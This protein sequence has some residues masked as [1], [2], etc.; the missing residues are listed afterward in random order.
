MCVTHVCRAWR[1]TALA[2]AT[3]WCYIRL[4]SLTTL[5]RVSIW[6]E[7]SQQ[8][9][10]DVFFDYHFKYHRSD[11]T[12]EL[13]GAI[14]R[15]MY[16]IRELEMYVADEDVFKDIGTLDYPLERLSV[17]PTS[18][19]EGQ[20]QLTLL[21]DIDT[22]FPHLTVL[23]LKYFDLD[24]DSIR[25]PTGLTDLTLWEDSSLST[26]ESSVEEMLKLLANLPL[27]EA[28]RCGEWY[29]SEDTPST[30]LPVVHLPRLR[31]LFLAQNLRPTIDLIA[32]LSVPEGLHFD[33]SIRV[34]RESIPHAANPTIIAPFAEWVKRVKQPWCTASF[35]LELEGFPDEDVPDDSDGDLIAG[36]F[37]LRLGMDIP[38]VVS[39][40]TAKSSQIVL[41]LASESRTFWQ[42]DFSDVFFSAF[43]YFNVNTM[44]IYTGD[45]DQTLPR[46]FSKLHDVETLW[47]LA[48]GWRGSGTGT[49]YEETLDQPENAAPGHETSLIFP[50]LKTLCLD[51]YDDSLGFGEII[52]IQD[53]LRRRAHAGSRLEKVVLGQNFIRPGRAI[54]PWHFSDMP[55]GIAIVQA[56]REELD[57]VRSD[58]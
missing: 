12:R 38:S 27:L 6:L 51:G 16:R 17:Q 29:L 11:Q 57:E 56:T 8:T 53:V 20:M 36:T 24:L 46:T 2:A 18:S 28:L 19:G 26:A 55:D 14:L 9:P 49:G 40:D 41:E 23:S 42:D 25:L 13:T 30:P 10:L 34:T 7:R 31:T 47:L 45:M 3:L 1:E 44:V 58:E 48:S 37:A 39:L 35:K 5:D 52:E 21:P 32:Q 54:L 15:Q 4:N 50:G 33:I 43:D 22:T